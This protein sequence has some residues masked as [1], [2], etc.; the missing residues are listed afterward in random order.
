MG[1]A[2]KPGALLDADAV[3]A[4][5]AGPGRGDSGLSA[6]GL[7]TSLEVV[8]VTGSTN[9]D[10]LAARWRRRARCSSRRSRSRGV[11]GWA[12]PG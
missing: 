1:A 12:G 4:A 8:A 6:G 2:S 7:W 9:A 10:L 11:A 3:R 5:L